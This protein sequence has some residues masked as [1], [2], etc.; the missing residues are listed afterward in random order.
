MPVSV[1]INNDRVTLP[2]DG[3]DQLRADVLAAVSAGGAFVR[4]GSAKGL[5]LL[6]TAA[7]SVSIHSLPELSADEIAG[8]DDTHVTFIDFDTLE[9]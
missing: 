1:R 5:E 9:S 6:V 3:V 4:V 7:S 8:D 2:D